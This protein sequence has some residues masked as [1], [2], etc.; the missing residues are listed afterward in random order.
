MTS[1]D[2][3][4]GSERKAEDVLAET[5]LPRAAS[6]HPTDKNGVTPQREDVDSGAVW[7]TEPGVLTKF[8]EDIWTLCDT[9]EYEPHRFT[10]VDSFCVS[11]WA[12]ANGFPMWQKDWSRFSFAGIQRGGRLGFAE[13]LHTPFEVIA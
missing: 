5:Y 4:Q 2:T 11:K 8:E 1:T 13:G 9:S 3:G 12:R 6:N 10:I 7:P